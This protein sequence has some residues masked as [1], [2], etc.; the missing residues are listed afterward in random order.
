MPNYS[1]NRTLTRCAGSRRLPRALAVMQST[2]KCPY[3]GQRTPL[4][5][6]GVTSWL[7]AYRTPCDHCHNLCTLQWHVR[8]VALAVG[9]AAGIVVAAAGSYLVFA[10]IAH[11]STVA[12]LVLCL[13]VVFI[14]G[15]VSKLAIALVCFRFGTLVKV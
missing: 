11:L 8:L 1:V 2:M 3:C 6:P 15:A 12:L 14:W 9:F 10:F 5:L 13:L 7:L 4:R